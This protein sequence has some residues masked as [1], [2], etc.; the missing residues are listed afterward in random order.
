[1]GLLY[2]IEEVYVH[3]VI[4]KFPFVQH[5]IIVIRTLFQ[6]RPLAVVYATEATSLS[7][8]IPAPQEM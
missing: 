8:F 3:V 6:I 1:M 4:M 7:S 2:E 5:K